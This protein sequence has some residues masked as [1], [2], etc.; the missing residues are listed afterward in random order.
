LTGENLPSPDL[1]RK[2]QPQ[3]FLQVLL[4]APL[5]ALLLYL[6][7]YSPANLQQDEECVAFIAACAFWAFFFFFRPFFF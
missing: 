2:S 5:L 3:F 7:T 4:S 6:Y 1:I